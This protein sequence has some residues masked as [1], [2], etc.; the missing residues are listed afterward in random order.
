MNIK[1]KSGF[2]C[3]IE[4]KILDDYEFIEALSE[5]EESPLRIKEVVDKLFGKNKS[6]AF[7]FVLK[8]CGYV[9]AKEIYQLVIDVFKSIKVGKNS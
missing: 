7:D 4:D 2:E 9:S 3:E 5:L 8:K 6:K 1:T